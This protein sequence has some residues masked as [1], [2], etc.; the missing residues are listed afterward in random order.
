MKNQKVINAFFD[1]AKKA[2]SSNGNLRI[3]TNSNKDRSLVNYNTVLAVIEDKHLKLNLTKYSQTTT[4][5][6]NCI[7]NSLKPYNFDKITELNNIER[8]TQHL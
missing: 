4:R 2:Q 7:L 5:I 6:Q 1:G 3:E 8:G